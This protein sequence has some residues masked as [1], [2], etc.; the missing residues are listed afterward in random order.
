[1]GQSGTARV[2]GVAAEVAVVMGVIVAAV[3]CITYLPGY[4]EIAPSWA[5]AP[6]RTVVV[7]K[8][9]TLAVSAARPIVMDEIEEACEHVPFWV[10]PVVAKPV[11]VLVILTR[12]GVRETE[13]RLSCD[14]GYLLRIRSIAPGAAVAA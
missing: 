2:G 14:T 12:A 1:M 10:R 13:A 6:E 3:W 5:T 7:A 11:S 8:E 9:D 4:D